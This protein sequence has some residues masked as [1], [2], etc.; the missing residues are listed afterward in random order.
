MDTWSSCLI[1]SVTSRSLNFCPPFLED[2][3]TLLVLDKIS[4]GE[5]NMLAPYFFVNFIYYSIA[6][7]F[8]EFVLNILT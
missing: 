3:S 6:L 2:F 1:V 5:K 4:G 7:C 8:N